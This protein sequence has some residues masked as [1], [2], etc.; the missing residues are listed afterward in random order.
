LGQRKSADE[1]SALDQTTAQSR[2]FDRYARDG[3]PAPSE[4]SSGARLP[5]GSLLLGGRLQITRN[6]GE[7]GMGA[8]YEAFDAER[9]TPVALKTILEPDAVGIYGLKNE[10]RALADVRHPN[11]VS[12]HELFYDSDQWFFTMDLVEGEP[13]DLWV[14]P[15]DR[16]DEGRL[17]ASLAQLGAA[18]KVIHRAGKLH[19]DL[20]PSNVLVTPAGRVIVLDFG[21]V[22]DPQLGGL[23][24]TGSGAMLVGTPAYMAPEQAAGGRA[25]EASD[26]YALGVMLYEALAGQ[27]PYA[28]T[29]GEVLAAKQWGDPRPLLAEE[30]PRDLRELT[31][32]LL[33]R[34]RAARPSVLV[35]GSDVSAPPSEAPVSPPRLPVQKTL[36]AR[37][38]E[39][40]AL[41]QA[42]R[43]TIGGRACVVVVE[44]ESGIGKTALCQTF[45]DEMRLERRAVVL[46]GRCYERESVPFKAF[47]PLIDE[48]MRY[49]RSLAPAHA[50]ALMP[51]DVFALAK[52]FPVL[53]R[54]AVIAEAPVRSG[55]A[56]NELRRRAFAALGELLARIR[57]RQP[58]VAYIDDLQWMDADSAA[59]LR[60]L[61]ISR[62][63]IPALLIVSH[64]TDDANRNPLLQ[65]V[66][67]AAISN[68][69]LGFERVPLGP[70]PVERTEELASGWLGA[71]AQ[72]P[73]LV[74]AIA[75]ESRGSPFFALEL[76]RFARGAPGEAHAVLS[77]SSVVSARLAGLSG[78]ARELL[79]ALALA[80][81]PMPLELM[82]DISAANHGDLDDL[83]AAQF[84][85]GSESGGHRLI[86]CYHD[87]IRENIGA[88][89]SA[90]RTRVLYGALARALAAHPKA[91]PELVS[92]CLEGAGDA[93]AAARYAT[94]AAD[95]ALAAMAF[96]HAAACFR[97]ALSLGTASAESRLS[98]YTRL[99]VALENAGR[100]LEAAEAYQQAAL[101]TEGETSA[102]LR[103]RAAEQLLATGHVAE[104]TLLFERVC[105]ELGLSWPRTTASA[106]VSLL[107]TRSRLR[108]RALDRDPASR[109]G[110]DSRA[111]ASA[112]A[113]ASTRLRL[114]TARSI[115][116]GF[117]G[118]MPVHAASV[119]SRYLLM[120]LE[121]DDLSHRVLS[122]GF[123]GY[124]HTLVAPSS[125]RAATLLAH[126]NALAERDASPE[127]V[128]FAALMNGAVAYHKNEFRSSRAHLRNAVLNLR[129]C[130]TVEWELDCANIYD[131]M[132]A[133]GCGDYADL[134][135]TTPALVE[136]A[137]RRGR[138]WAYT[139]LSGFA[140]APA[141]LGPDDPH[142]YRAQ[143]DEVK[144]YWRRS[145]APLW[146]DY[147]LLMGETM[148]AVYVGDPRAAFELLAAEHAVYSRSQLTRGSGIGA[149]GYAFHRARAAAAT[150][151]NDRAISP[152]LRRAVV[153]TL[154][155]STVTLRAH[156]INRS[157]GMAQTIEAVLALDRG[158]V[159]ASRAALTRAVEFFDSGDTVLLAASARHRL[160]ELT[161]GERGDALMR[162]AADQ[163]RAEGVK[164]LEAM[165]E[166]HCPGCRA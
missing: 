73:A 23:G 34:D 95:D 16:L 22:A 123:N 142:G 135:R 160:G 124:V 82:L 37:E 134:A 130:A 155:E 149:A 42:Y 79:E 25:S 116:T 144:L 140:G 47:D 20:K 31:L 122:L 69:L 115:V 88:G 139:M 54:V 11:L 143:I 113:S 103:R 92:R 53:G 75:K 128:G 101:L 52:L 138:V 7:G 109:A 6:I 43:G 104:G 36:L 9:R 65:G 86:D 127:L 114:E 137:R 132:S 57:D 12:L 152:A 83:R 121:T 24:Q 107:W 100:G 84:V 15:H 98:L 102:D 14:R 50:A 56:P 4:T 17:R 55:L 163:I 44:G 165:I 85:R 161:G 48:L 8:V 153:T 97:R 76:A 96:E 61:L 148:L 70:L 93:E 81:R 3:L 99:G 118:Y 156:G 164:N 28:G 38:A 63:P 77:L 91:D 117:I 108:L 89:L 133:Y 5:V 71:A 1:P 60:H 110:H 166:L 46:S 62:E 126:M 40:E 13:F 21:L 51:R 87:R 10:F 145:K 45:L 66:L 112:G 147:V 157:L 129:A 32:R 26:F 136:E 35:L 151:R 119:A 94:V 64:R 2:S 67:A 30:G 158:D 19:R 68:R 111:P 131:Q 74:H 162:T 39:L 106:F 41:R 154:E 49:L 27:L 72:E 125:E 80:G 141:W 146:P 159:S 59:L 33:A 120:A 90:A 150:L 29:A 58:L 18:V 78:A 105:Q